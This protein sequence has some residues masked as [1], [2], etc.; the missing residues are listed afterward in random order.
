MKLEQSNLIVKRAY[1]EVY[2]CDEGIVKVFEK[3]HSKADVFNEA[4]NTARVEEAGL[5]IP[6]VKSVTEIDGNGRLLLNTK[7]ERHLER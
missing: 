7:T 4:L 5:D 6:K 1:K 2:K 3:T